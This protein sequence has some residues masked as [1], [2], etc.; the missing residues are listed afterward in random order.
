MDNLYHT[1]HFQF[2]YSRFR[3]SHVGNI[4][5]VTEVNILNI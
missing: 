2:P 4:S 3:N 1:P 5:D